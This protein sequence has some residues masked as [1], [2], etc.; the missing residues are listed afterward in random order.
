MWKG[1]MWKTFMP[2]SYEFLLGVRPKLVKLLALS[3]LVALQCHFFGYSLV[4]S[5]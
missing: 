5:S 2:F 3:E 4:S 1:I